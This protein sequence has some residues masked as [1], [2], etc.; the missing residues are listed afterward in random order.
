MR[1][2]SMCESKRKAYAF[3]RLSR[4]PH[5]G[6]ELARPAAAPSKRSKRRAPGFAAMPCSKH[7]RTSPAPTYPMTGGR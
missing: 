3:A 1:E 6:P 7:S 5:T 2:R 4:C